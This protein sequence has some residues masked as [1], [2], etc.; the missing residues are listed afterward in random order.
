MRAVFF[1]V[2]SISLLALVFFGY[3][4]REGGSIHEQYH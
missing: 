1:Y 3:D 2:Q 4:K